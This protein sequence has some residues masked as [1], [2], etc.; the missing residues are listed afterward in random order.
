[1]QWYVDQRPPETKPLCDHTT[2]LCHLC[3]AARTN[4]TTMV[5]AVKRQC[6]CGTN[7][8]PNWFCACMPEDDGVERQKPC[9]CLTCECE[10]CSQCKVRTKQFIVFSIFV[11]DKMM[12]TSILGG[13]P[14]IRKHSSV[15]PHTS[16]LRT[17][18]QHLRPLGSFLN[19]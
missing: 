6:V 18:F 17:F 4:F 11:R 7:L 16:T 14:E 2:G 1:M 10:K 15:L 19:I 9:Q 12:L 8:C 13:H 3:E 5:K